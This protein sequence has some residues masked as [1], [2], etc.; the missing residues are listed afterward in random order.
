MK[1]KTAVGGDGVD[2]QAYV[3]VATAIRTAGRTAA[4]FSSSMDHM[5]RALEKAKT[6]LHAILEQYYFDLEA[7]LKWEDE[8]GPCHDG[9]D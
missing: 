7:Q 3:Y 2:P 6:Q 4:S 9:R 8:G 1:T 5:I